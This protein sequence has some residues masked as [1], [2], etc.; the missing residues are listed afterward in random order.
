MATTGTIELC[1]QRQTVSWT[2]GDQG[3]AGS[4]STPYVNHV[5]DIFVVLA[6]AIAR[7][8][9]APDI[10]TPFTTEPRFYI[11]SARLS[12]LVTN[13]SNVDIVVTCYPWVARYDNL[14]PEDLYTVPTALETSTGLSGAVDSDTINIGW[15]PFQARN[16]TENVKLLKPR[17]VRLQGGQSY[18]FKMADSKPLYIN[19]AR[20]AGSGADGTNTNQ[21]ISGRTRGCFFIMK[22]NTAVSAPVDAGANWAGGNVHIVSIR[23]YKWSAIPMPFHFNDNAPNTAD[24]TAYNIIAPQTGA[25]VAPIVV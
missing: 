10:T 8:V 11:N 14:I 7:T 23:T 16:V 12:H 19:H 15:T 9:A 3:W 13:A 18:N 21:S 4:A 22:A 2:P 6:S 20:I 17:G 25:A 5:N 24:V 1:A